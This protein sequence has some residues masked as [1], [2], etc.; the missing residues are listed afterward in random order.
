[1][2]V[3]VCVVCKDEFWIVWWLGCVV[4]VFVVEGDVLWIVVVGVYDVD[5]GWV[6]M[7][8]CESDWL[9]VGWLGWI[10]VDVLWVCYVM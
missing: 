3:V 10:C 5:L 8:W 2:K 4:V 9:I 1:M 6:R 7:V